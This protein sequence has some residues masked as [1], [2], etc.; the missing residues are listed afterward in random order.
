M[1]TF[2]LSLVLSLTGMGLFAQEFEIPDTF[3]P[4]NKQEYAT[5]EPAVLQAIDWL[6]D[7]PFNQQKTKRRAVNAFLMKWLT[8][9]PAVSIHLK[10]RIITFSECPNCLMIFMGGWTKY[11]LENQDKDELK[12]SMAGIEKVIAFY[13]A[14]KQAMGKNKAIEKYIKLKEKGKLK[15]YVETNI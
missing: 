3:N 11:S 5:F 2:F 15:T 12:G 8:G 7:T 13:T 4:K 6:L 10:P 14:N 1:K 9:S